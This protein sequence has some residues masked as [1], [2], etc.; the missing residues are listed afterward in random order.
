MKHYSHGEVNI[1]QIKKL[2]E[3]LRQV[4]C[5]N[6]KYIIA[7]SET[8]GNFHCVEKKESVEM[9]EKE[10]VLYMVNTESVN[11]FCAHEGR[12]DSI[13]LEPSIWEIDKAKEYDHL[14]QET[15]NVAD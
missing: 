4:K 15:R 7:D 10:G 13:T 3:G 9:Y 2:P 1:F 5:D 11:V 12:H 14:T 6:D 8:T